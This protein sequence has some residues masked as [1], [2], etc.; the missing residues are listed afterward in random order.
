VEYQQPLLSSNSTEI[1]LIHNPKEKLVNDDLTKHE[2]KSEPKNES[3]NEPKN[4]LKN[5]PKNESRNVLKNESKN[6]SINESK[7]ESI[8]ESKSESKNESKSES[9]NESKYESKYEAKNE[10]KNEPKNEHKFKNDMV[11]VDYINSSIDEVRDSIDISRHPRLSCISNHSTASK[12]MSDNSTNN[13]ASERE[14][15]LKR[16]CGYIKNIWERKIKFKNISKNEIVILVSENEHSFFSTI[17][18]V[19]IGIAS[20]PVGLN[21]NIKKE[22]PKFLPKHDIVPIQTKKED[23]A[24]YIK[25]ITSEVHVT[26]FAI[27]EENGE[28]FYQ[29]LKTNDVLRIGEKKRIDC[30]YVQKYSNVNNRLNAEEYKKIFDD[31]MEQ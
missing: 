27:I 30:A 2:P 15:I 24:S 13:K 19:E 18:E 10:S 22:K 4:E 9:K 16:M 20:G 6:E 28:K 21:F 3:K 7:N 17:H 12:P 8:N 29:R 5:K 14:S 25:V 26:Y 11:E 1:L 31:F 23:K